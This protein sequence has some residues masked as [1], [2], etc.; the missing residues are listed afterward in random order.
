[1]LTLTLLRH[2]KSSWTELGPEG[3]P[4]EDY[5]RPLANRGMRDAPAIAAWMAGARLAPD[6]VL[7][8]PAARTRQT[9]ALVRQQI[10]SRNPPVEYRHELY[11]IGSLALLQR[12]QNTSG[13][14]AHVLVVGH[15][16]G[17]GE[18]AIML[19]GH[20]A[21]SLRLALA[22]KFPTCGVAVIDFELPIW[23]AIAPGKGRLREFM[24]PKSLLTNHDTKP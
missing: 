18:L 16:P 24:T 1:M 2:A 19:A 4:V 21:P 5:D 15:N 7:C 13:H 22:E 12:L 20:G 6:M 3:R 14:A 17:L 9:W 10:H 11:L 8:S 23:R